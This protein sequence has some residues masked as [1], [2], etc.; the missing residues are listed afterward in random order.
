MVFKRI[1]LHK[2][3]SLGLWGGNCEGRCSVLE[4]KLGQNS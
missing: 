2:L 1:G 4:A 3:L